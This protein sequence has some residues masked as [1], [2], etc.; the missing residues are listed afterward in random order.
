MSFKIKSVKNGYYLSNKLTFSRTKEE[1]AIFSFK[2]ENIKCNNEYLAVIAYYDRSEIILKPKED[3]IC[4]DQNIPKFTYDKLYKKIEVTDPFGI[5]YYLTNCQDYHNSIIFI[6]GD[7]CNKCK[8]SKV[9]NNDNLM[10]I[11]M[12]D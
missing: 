10:V 7:Q 3:S 5:K 2:N 8:L 4:D 12:L 11:E 1:A 9:S 6:C